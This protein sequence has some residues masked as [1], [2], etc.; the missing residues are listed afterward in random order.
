M[1]CV[2]LPWTFP[3]LEVSEQ[4]GTR[5]FS[6]SWLVIWKAREEANKRIYQNMSLN[7]T[8]SELKVTWAMEWK[9]A[10]NQISDLSE[11]LSLKL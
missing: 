7:F 3:Y 11:T 6:V 1:K 9:T 8:Y 4:S 10:Y 2:I 5:M